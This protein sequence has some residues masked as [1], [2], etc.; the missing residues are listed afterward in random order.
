MNMIS[1]FQPHQNHLAGRDCVFLGRWKS[2]LIKCTP[3]VETIWVQ[4]LPPTTQQVYGLMSLQAHS[5][6][7]ANGHKNST[8]NLRERQD[9]IRNCLS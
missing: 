8:W 3:S 9:N 2:V 1:V 6:S 5:P 7:Q 4:S